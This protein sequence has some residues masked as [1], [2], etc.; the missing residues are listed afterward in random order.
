MLD[1]AREVV[2]LVQGRTRQDLSTDRLFQLAVTRLIGVVG[3][4]ARVAVPDYGR[5]AEIVWPDVVGGYDT[6]EYDVIWELATM[7]VPALIAAL[8]ASG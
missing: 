7:Q 8:E 1:R 6:V 2:A 3:E 4:T 5:D